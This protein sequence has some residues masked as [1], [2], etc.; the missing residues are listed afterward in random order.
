[1]LNI[2]L[3]S[4]KITAK[5]KQKGMTQE[6]LADALF[7][8]RQAVSKWEMGKSLPSIDSLVEMTKLFDVTIDYILDGSEINDHDYQSMFMQYPRESVIYHFLN[9]N[10]INDDIKNIFY[11][12]TTKERR[13]IIDQLI[14]RQL[15]L[16]V[17]MLWPYLS[18]SERKYLLGNF[19]SKNIDQNL[20][21]IYDMMSTEEKM[22][23]DSKHEKTFMYIINKQKGEKN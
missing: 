4:K 11:L 5:R 20:S 22:M 8:S 10:H 21:S 16:D 9:S 15:K 2:D 6:E 7:V 13:Q 23:M 19:I 18:I 17:D 1:M 12:L 3:I 14:T